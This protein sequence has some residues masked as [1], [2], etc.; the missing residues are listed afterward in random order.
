MAIT[1]NATSNRIFLDPDGGIDT[2]FTLDDIVTAQPLYASNNGSTYT[3]TASIIVVGTGTE[4]AILTATNSTL[5]FTNGILGNMGGRLEL[6]ELATADEIPRNGCT[7]IYEGNGSSHGVDCYNK[8]SDRDD[9]SRDFPL[10][11]TNGQIFIYNTQYQVIGNT[12]RNDMLDIRNNATEVDIRDCIFDGNTDAGAP[13]SYTHVFCVNTYF[14]DVKIVNFG[15]LEIGAATTKEWSGVSHMI[16]SLGLSTFQASATQPVK[17]F[18]LKLQQ[19]ATFGKRPSDSYCQLTNLEF[20]GAYTFEAYSGTYFGVWDL[21]YTV[22]VT[23]I[24]DGVLLEDCRTAFTDVNDNITFDIL[25]DINGVIPQQRAKALTSEF[26]QDHFNV[27]NNPFYFRAWKYGKSPV[28]IPSSVNNPVVVSA[29]MVDNNFISLDKATADLVTIDFQKPAVVQ[30]LV[31]GDFDDG[32]QMTQDASGAALG[33]WYSTNTTY[34]NIDIATGKMHLTR[35]YNVSWNGGAIIYQNVNLTNGVVYEITVKIDDMGGATQFRFGFV[36]YN[37]WILT[38]TGEY[39]FQYTATGTETLIKINTDPG[40]Y[41]NP[42]IIDYFKVSDPASASP[43]IDGGKEY[44]Y[45]CD[46]LGSSISDV[47]HKLASMWADVPA[48]SEPVY[49]ISTLKKEALGTVDGINYDGVQGILFE[50]FTGRLRSM[51][52]DDDTTYYF[53]LSV[54]FNITGLETGSDVVLLEA[55]TDTV[56]DSIDQIVGTEYAYSYTYSIDKQ[57]DIGIIK[58]GFVTKYLYGYTLSGVDASLPVQQL[59]DRNY[60]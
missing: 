15:V 31:D 53:P 49:P 58:P 35:N 51:V 33:V 11:Y 5:H 20:D 30:S 14:E 36:N 4:R 40:N 47:Y 17:L 46:C 59:I 52:S 22:D 43:Y 1:Y 28:E 55:G 38:S 42:T 9:T 6:G 2:N 13:P 18:G 54:T 25:T 37:D 56:I 39:T 27:D 7:I 45:K 60:Q 24:A 48:P 26:N 3:F 19:N 29:T 32:L 12:T 16:G 41:V 10:A 44:S 34:A 50:N 8:S 23:A 57:I 21:L